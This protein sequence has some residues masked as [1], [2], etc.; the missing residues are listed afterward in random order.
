MSEPAP[1]ALIDNIYDYPMHEEDD[2]PEGPLHWRWSGYVYNV[3]KA[4]YADRFVS[5]DVCIYWEPRNFS[6]YVAPDAFLAAGRVPDPP[7]RV[8][9]SWLL[10]EVVFAAEIGSLATV[11]RGA[12]LDRYQVRLRPAE[13]L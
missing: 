1:T 4:R 9:R 7:P 2:V 10:P 13:V 5:G 12:K 6:A 3:L 8:Y 11:E